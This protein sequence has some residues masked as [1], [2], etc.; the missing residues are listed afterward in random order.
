MAEQIFDPEA[1]QAKYRFWTRSDAPKKTYSI[2]FTPR[3]GS[4]W[5]TSILTE[6]KAMGT[7]T[8]WFNPQLMVTSTRAKGARDIDQ[9]VAAIS[10]HNIHGDMFGFEITSHQIRATFG[11]AD[12]FM[13]HFSDA[14]FFWLIR[15]DIVAQGVSLHKMVQ[16]QV[17][18]SANSD[19]DA[20]AKSDAS[21][22]YDAGQIER[23]IK[24]IRH[25]EIET[26]A[27]I[28]RFGL[29]PVRL[30]Y[31]GITAAGANETVGLFADA[32]GAKLAA[33]DELPTTHRKIGTE[34]NSE[35]A[36]RFRAEK[37]DFV[38][39]LEDERAEMVAMH[40]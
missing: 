10:R 19:A 39:R 35:Y 31:E 40:P 22:S 24:H 17:G 1:D 8:E 26:E 34:K 25:A 23:W 30:S 14:F 29:S 9:F 3:S 20:I 33:A 16:T 4:S 2:L 21:Y 28:A 7:P 12:G 15:K 37:H 36:T 18:H 38:A 11:G 6:T 27:M 5:L 32:L 13:S